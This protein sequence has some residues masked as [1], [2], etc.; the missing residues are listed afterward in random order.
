MVVRDA[1][2][3]TQAWVHTGWFQMYII[4]GQLLLHND[5]HSQFHSHICL[6]SVCYNIKFQAN[7]Y[8]YPNVNVSVIGPMFVN[9]LSCLR[10]LVFK[11]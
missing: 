6:A 4:F 8:V 9:E 2:V 3:V 10:V 5:L 11:I 7:I 1:V